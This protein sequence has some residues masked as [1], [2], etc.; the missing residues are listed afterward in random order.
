MEQTL[1]YI[2]KKYSLR[3]WVFKPKE[4]RLLEGT[5]IRLIQ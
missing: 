3:Q 1:I 5:V 4:L 2:C